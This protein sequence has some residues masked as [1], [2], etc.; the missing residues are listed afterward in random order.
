MTVHWTILTPTTAAGAVGAVRLIAEA[1]EELDAALQ[2]SGLAPLARGVPRVGEVRLCDLLAIDHGLLVRWNEV[3]VDL[4]P[5]GGPLV[6]RQLLD[7]LNKRGI[8]GQTVQ[9]QAWRA[10]QPAAQDELEALMLDTLARAASPRATTLLLAAL[11]QWRQTGE[12][13]R[14]AEPTPRDRRLNRLVEPPLVVLVGAANIGKSTLINALARRAVSIVDAQP[15]S[16]RDHVGVL[17]QLDGLV[18]RVV[19]TPGLRATDDPIERDAQQAAITMATSADLLLLCGDAGTALP[20]SPI[21]RDTP[22]LRVALRSDLGV[23][24]WPHDTMLSAARQEGVDSLAIRVRQALI[25]DADLEV[26]EPWVFWRP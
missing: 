19:D 4:F 21:R 8:A 5:H 12:I 14:E 16:T 18:A 26:G 1:A 11:G 23:P 15:G 2:A 17:L 3:C 20:S 22:A 9:G 6:Q 24:Q 7:A 10:R 13:W 25:S